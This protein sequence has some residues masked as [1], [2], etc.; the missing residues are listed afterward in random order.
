M[1]FTFH[2]A[3]RILDGDIG[4][5]IFVSVPFA[6]AIWYF[7]YIYIRPARQLEAALRSA[8][9]HPLL[10]EKES[11]GTEQNRLIPGLSARAHGKATRQMAL[12]GAES[13]NN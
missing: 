9:A 3:E 6:L 8:R 4:A 10:P 13:E 5:I 11:H 2:L 7:I 12:G 1:Q